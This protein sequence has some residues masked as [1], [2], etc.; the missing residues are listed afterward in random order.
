MQPSPYTP[1]EIANIVPGRARQI[2]EFDERL[3]L[4]VDLHRFI[5]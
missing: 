4:L 5:G 3:S 2:A 1:G